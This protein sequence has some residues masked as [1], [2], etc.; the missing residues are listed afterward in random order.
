MKKNLLLI[1]AGI[2][3]LQCKKAPFNDLSGDYTLKGIVMVYD[4][5]SGVVNKTPGKNLRVYLKYDNGGTNYLNYVTAND[6]GQYS[7]S[8]I[9][10]NKGYLIY[11]ES[12]P[13]LKY[14]G[15]LSYGAGSYVDG[16]S[17]TLKLYPSQTGQ[18]GIHLIVRDSAGAPIPH[19]TAWVFSS[20]V[21]FAADS[22]AGRLFDITT[23]EYGAGNSY[24][25]A[26]GIYY[27]RIRTKIG[28]LSLSGESTVT[29]GEAGIQ[30]S[31]IYL[32][33]VPPANRNGIEITVW[34][35]YNTAVDGAK[36][37]FYRSNAVFIADT[38]YQHSLF[39]LTSSS[40]GI[41]SSYILDPATYFYKA[42]KVV[43]K[44][45][46]KFGPGSISVNGTQVA[47]DT[48]ILQ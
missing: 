16:A 4:T 33:S 47:R 17:D 45:S 27:L 22:S 8:G 6:Q 13:D 46:L 14:Y 44:D 12:K 38:S 24:N 11:A 37:Y 42:L 20:A 32:K 25:I 28:N 40:A 19:T 2:L 15:E 21:L 23:N 18:N 36:V 1:I 30:N 48:I 10:K 34:D 5:L 9:E 35:A 41:A 3:L 31:T 29:V 7:F 26:P 43:D 39:T